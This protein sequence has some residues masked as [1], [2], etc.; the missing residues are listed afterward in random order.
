MFWGWERKSSVEKS[1]SSQI[2]YFKST[3]R[4]PKIHSPYPLATVQNA[5]F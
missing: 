1:S 5:H 4:E 3:P 2:P